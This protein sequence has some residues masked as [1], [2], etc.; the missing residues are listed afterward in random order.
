MKPY[1]HAKISQK[2][3]GG[4]V[5]DYL[6][7]HDWVDHTKAHLPDARHRMILHNSWGIYIGES[8]FGHIF[9]NS[10]GKE[11]NVRDILEQHVIDDLGKIPTIDECFAS[12]PL[13]PWMVGGKLER[14]VLK[15]SSSNIVIVD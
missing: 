15:I 8:V 5:K 11:I 4:E 12:M 1:Y 7:F 6:K 10:A 13:E 14:S 3:F 9:V 2:R